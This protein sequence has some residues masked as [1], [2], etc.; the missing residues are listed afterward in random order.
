MITDW[1]VFHNEQPLVFPTM[2][3]DLA[4]LDIS[5]FPSIDNFE[6]V[7]THW[8][9]PIGPH[10]RFWSEKLGQLASFPW[11]DNANLAL[12]TCTTGDIPIG[13][14]EKPYHD[15][16]QGWQTLIFQVGEYVYIMQ[17]GEPSEEPVVWTS[18]F[19]VPLDQ[20]I[21]EWRREIRRFNPAIGDEMPLQGISGWQGPAC[22]ACRTKTHTGIR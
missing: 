15:S 16:E 13:T 9:T 8:D 10:I 5:H 20:Y 18:W 22:L 12:Y 6:V 21:S 19:R 11:W 17:G 4:A 3:W 2:E 1:P 7:L 14:I